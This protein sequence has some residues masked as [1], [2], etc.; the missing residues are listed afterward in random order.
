M[1]FLRITN[2]LYLKMAIFHEPIYILVMIP[3]WVTDPKPLSQLYALPATRKESENWNEADSFR[4]T[5]ACLSGLEIA[6]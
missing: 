1:L 4:R 6:N 2:I 3:Q 5:L